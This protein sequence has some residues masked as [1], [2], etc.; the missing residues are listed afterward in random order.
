MSRYVLWTCVP[1]VYVLPLSAHLFDVASEVGLNG[2]CSVG[3][4]YDSVVC[5]IHLTLKVC[6]HSVSESI[7]TS[8]VSAM[9]ATRERTSQLSN[10]ESVRSARY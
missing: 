10:Q 5:R 1:I 8:C 7:S 3:A 6:L 2:K 4:A 9:M